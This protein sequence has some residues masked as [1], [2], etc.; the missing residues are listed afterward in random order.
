MAGKDAVW[1]R[2]VDT[3]GGKAFWKTEK[4][5]KYFLLQRNIAEGTAL[6]SFVSNLRNTF[7]TTSKMFRILINRPPKYLAIAETN[8]QLEVHIIIIIFISFISSYF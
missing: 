8:N 5:N 4:E 6:S 7:K 1:L 3:T 2:G